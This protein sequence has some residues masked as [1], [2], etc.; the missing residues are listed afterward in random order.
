MLI[1]NIIH[2]DPLVVALAPPFRRSRRG[3]RAAQSAVEGSR[4]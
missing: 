4:R 3:A 2:F 1:R